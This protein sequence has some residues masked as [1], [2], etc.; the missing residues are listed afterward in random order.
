[1]ELKISQDKEKQQRLISKRNDLYTQIDGLRNELTECKDKNY[2]LRWELYNQR[3]ARYANIYAYSFLE[4]NE[5]TYEELLQMEEQIGSV[6]RG[7]K[8]E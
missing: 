3:G 1:M 7:L 4:P 2:N 5:L 6:S 8:P